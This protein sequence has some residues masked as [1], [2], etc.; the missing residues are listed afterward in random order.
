[1]I[2]HCEKGTKKIMNDV[3]REK[4][5]NIIEESNNIVDNGKGGGIS[6]WERKDSKYAQKR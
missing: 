3:E 2:V 6:A 1:M 4:L 5:K